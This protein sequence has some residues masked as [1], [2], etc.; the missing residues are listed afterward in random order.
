MKLER[1]QKFYALL[2]AQ[3][4]GFRI[5]FKNQSTL[6]KIIGYILFFNKSFMTSFT[7]TIG[8]TVYFPTEEHLEKKGN[9]NAISTLAHE[10][11][12]AKDADKISAPLFGLLYLIP[13]AVAP[14]MWFFA[15]YHWALGLGLFLLFL[16]PLPAPMRMYYELR[17]Y[18][19]SLFVRNEIYKEK[20]ISKPN[21]RDM[22]MDLVE[23]YNKQFTSANYYF[24]WP[25]GVTSQLEK[26]V[27]DII[28]EKMIE[29]DDIYKEIVKAFQDS[30]A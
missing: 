20:G 3:M 27:N 16:A 22:L 2:Q 11:Q 9:L 25:F 30:K 28:S 24:M 5:K 17:G 14:F 29:K 4:D 15:F 7:T 19:M 8:K 10:Y 18:T 26:A 6:M 12:H 21:R 13:L 1:F 23:A